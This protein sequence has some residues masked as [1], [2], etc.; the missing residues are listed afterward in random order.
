[1]RAN[2][3]NI[4]RGN[5]PGLALGCRTAISSV[6]VKAAAPVLIIAEIF[7]GHQGDV[8]SAA[9]APQCRCGGDVTWTEQAASELVRMCGAATWRRVSLLPGATC[10]D[11]YI[12]PDIPFLSLFAVKE[13]SVIKRRAQRRRSWR[14]REKGGLL[15][16]M[17]DIH[18]CVS[19]SAGS[20]CVLQAV[21]IPSL[22]SSSRR[23]AYKPST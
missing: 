18:G 5:L 9:P 22:S 12:W 2:S 19:I 8:R 21:N 17:G 3:S 10:R 4:P 14:L 20:C 6:I 11:A 16:D 13:Y 23:G 15:E 7:P 1:M